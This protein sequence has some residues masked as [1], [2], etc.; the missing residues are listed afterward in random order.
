MD[1]KEI[2]WKKNG[3]ISM[4]SRMNSYDEEVMNDA[5]DLLFAFFHRKNS[6]LEDL[7]KAYDFYVIKTL[8]KIIAYPP[9]I[10]HT[11]HHLKTK[12]KAIQRLIKFTREYKQVIESCINLEY[13][14]VTPSSGAKNNSKQHMEGLIMQ[15][16]IKN[17]NNFQHS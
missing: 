17:Y 10:Q 9:V 13:D 3:H 4:L 12:T 6:H 14:F 1:A 11:C 2:F 8:L 16:S 7:A 5:I 15:L